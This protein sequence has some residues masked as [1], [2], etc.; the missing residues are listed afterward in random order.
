LIPGLENESGNK[1]S[2]LGLKS[3]DE[4]VLPA[5]EDGEDS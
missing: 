2:G 4:N 3:E 1:R 5:E